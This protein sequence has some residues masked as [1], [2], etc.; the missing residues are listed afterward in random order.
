MHD[1]SP[2]NEATS[3]ESNSTLS[4]EAIDTQEASRRRIEE[5]G[6]VA[7]ASRALFE[8]EEQANISL[9]DTCEDVLQWL[10]T[11]E[12]NLRSTR[13]EFESALDRYRN[14]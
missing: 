7:E 5:A 2:E 1:V 4:V 6:R 3:P 10:K 12:C 9:M 11:T 14:A 8:Q 13:R